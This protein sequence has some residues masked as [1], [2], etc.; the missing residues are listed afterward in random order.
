VLFKKMGIRR[1]YPQLRWLMAF[2]EEVVK[3]EQGAWVEQPTV[4]QAAAMWEK[5]EAKFERRGGGREG[6]LAWTTLVNYWRPRR[7]E[8]VPVSGGSGT[9]ESKEA[10]PQPQR[11]RK[12]SRSSAAS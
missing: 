5:V 8:L 10:E 3:L 12:R 2:V 7:G 6:Q 9:E 11:P 4:L 1:V